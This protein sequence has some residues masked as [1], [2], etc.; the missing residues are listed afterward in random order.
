MLYIILTSLSLAS[1]LFSILLKVDKAT[2][3]ALPIKNPSSSK[4][5]GMLP[6]GTL[7]SGR[8]CL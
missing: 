7:L 8:A 1:I 3:G 6:T 5:L 4:F 2:L